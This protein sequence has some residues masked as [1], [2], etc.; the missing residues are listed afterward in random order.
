MLNASLIGYEKNMFL[1]A[2]R[3][4]KVLA[5]KLGD[6]TEKC[7]VSF[8]NLNRN[9]T[10]NSQPFGI[11]TLSP[12]EQV[13]LISYF[14]EV[15]KEYGF[16]IDTC[17]EDIDLSKFGVSHAHCIDKDRLERIGNFKLD[18]EKDENQRGVCDVFQ[19]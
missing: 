3:Y 4:F 6:Y 8:L 2:I 5:S 12:T 13:E 17:A 1:Y 18:I 16:Y 19:V 10:R 11:R 9:T 15:E 14:S 7:T